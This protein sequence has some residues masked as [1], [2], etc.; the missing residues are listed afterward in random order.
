[1]DKR[2]FLKKAGLGGLALASGAMMWS[3]GG[4]VAEKAPKVLQ[5]V[6]GI[7]SNWVWLRPQID[8]SDDEWKKR[9]EAMRAAGIEAVLPEIYN[10]MEALFDHPN[11]P[12]KARVLE[13]I[14]PLAK[15]AGL[16]VHAWMWTMPLRNPEYRAKHPDWYAV[17]RKG[18]SAHDKPAYVSYYNFMCPCH[19]EVPEFVKGNVEAL[20]KIAEVDGI[21]LDYVRLPDVILAKALQPKYNIVQDQ[22]YP[23]YDYSYSENC[24]NQ[25][26]EKTGIDPMD[27]ADP[28][29]HE[30]WYQFRYDAISNIVN[31]YAV[32]TAKKYNKTITAA[33]FPNWESVRQQWH[34]WDLDAFLPMLYNEFYDE[35][36]PWI[37]AQVE[38][39]LG[40][41]NNSKP[42]YSGL[43]VPSLSPE[44]LAKAIQLSREGGAKGVSFFDYGAI[45]D[46]H[47]AV[48]EKVLKS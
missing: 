47:W 20:A 25:F 46:E 30:E 10:G 42:I 7:P 38:A 26:K 4:E 45:K 17:N 2:T 12:V 8:L 23:A 44:D 16:Q 27:I 48:I 11:F 33:V 24:R 31:N 40:R 5:P 13:Q 35:D 6:S 43:Y 41:L 9:F 15:Q 18:E 28:A 39:A 36:V 34:K 19:P 1:M 32:P 3:C 22:E 37:K 14:L 29:A 21:H